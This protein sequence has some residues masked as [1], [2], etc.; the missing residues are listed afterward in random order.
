M[1]LLMQ[2]FTSL[3]PI[4]GKYLGL[5]GTNVSWL[6]FL[7]ISPIFAGIGTRKIKKSSAL[8]PPTVNLYPDFKE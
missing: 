8:P 6:P 5:R 3:A 2:S 7:R 1:D 4:S